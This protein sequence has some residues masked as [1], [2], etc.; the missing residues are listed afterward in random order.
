MSIKNILKGRIDRKNYIL[1]VVLTAAIIFIVRS[2]ILYLNTETDLL[3][4]G[5]TTLFLFLG[6]VFLFILSLRRLHDM[7]KSPYL[8]LLWFVPIINLVFCVI[9][10]I[11]FTENRTNKHG[12]RVPAYVSYDKVL[13]LKYQTKTIEEASADEDKRNPIQERVNILK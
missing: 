10:M 13:F 5:A 4:T 11:A 3:L 2:F 8:N 9:L 12:T 7:G 1:S 6:F